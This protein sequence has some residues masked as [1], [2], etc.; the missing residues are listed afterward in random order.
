MFAQRNGVRNVNL[1]TNGLLPEKLFP[2]MDRMLE[3]CPET[4]IDLNFSLDG[5]AK[6]HDSIR[7]VPNNFE[8]TLA[9]MAEAS[10]RYRGVRRL[11]LNV[12]TVITRENQDEVERLAG[13]LKEHA[14]IDGHY[15]E[16]V[17]GAGARPVAEDPDARCRGAACTGV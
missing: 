11:R 4:S 2:A 6:T 12:L 13:Y 16:I 3:A 17:R 14:V 8:R 5:L 1:P 10:K 9:T 7:G 15:F